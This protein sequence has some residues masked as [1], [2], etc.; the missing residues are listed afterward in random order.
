MRGPHSSMNANLDCY[1]KPYRRRWD[2]TQ[3][4]L[5]KLLGYEAG[6]VVSRFERGLRDP[7]LENAYALEII[8]GVPSAELFSSLYERVKRE[9]IARARARYD[10]LQ[11]DPSKATRLKLDFFE[12][13]F[14]RADER[15][16]SKIV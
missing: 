16:S 10:D 12:E 3:T 2:L 1:L 4:E 9:V 8:L 13:V 14:A 6:A 7:S 5:A 11:G 15:A